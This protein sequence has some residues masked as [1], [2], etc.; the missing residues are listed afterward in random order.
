MPSQIHYCD[1]CNAE[2]CYLDAIADGLC[3]RCRISYFMTG[4]SL[5]EFLG[6]TEILDKD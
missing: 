5:D 2:I 4:L 3:E 6:E 1:R